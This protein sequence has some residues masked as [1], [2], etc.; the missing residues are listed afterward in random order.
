MYICTYIHIYIHWYGYG[1]NQTDLCI[2]IS[3]YGRTQRTCGRD[4][5]HSQTYTY[6]CIYTHTN[7]NTHTYTFT[8]QGTLIFLLGQFDTLFESR[9]IYW[10]LIVGIPW[11]FVECFVVMKHGNPYCASYSGRVVKP[12]AILIFFVSPPN[13]RLTKHL[14]HTTV[15]GTNTFPTGKTWS[16]NFY[17]TNQPLMHVTVKK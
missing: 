2:S 4:C 8:Y 10:K 5:P 11:I 16:L 13:K 1:Q 17:P 9:V 12:N 14:F 6:T 3:I 7:W 15:W